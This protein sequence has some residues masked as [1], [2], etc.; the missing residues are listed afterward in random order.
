MFRTSSGR[1]VRSAGLAC[2]CPNWRWIIRGRLPYIRVPEVR[3]GEHRGGIPRPDD[4]GNARLAGWRTE[5]TDM[6]STVAVSKSTDLQPCPGEP[7]V[8]SLG[9]PIAK[10]GSKALDRALS[11][12]AALLVAAIVDRSS[13]WGRCLPRRG[14]LHRRQ[15]LAR[16]PTHRVSGLLTCRS[17]TSISRCDRGKVMYG[18]HRSKRSGARQAPTCRPSSID[19]A[20]PWFF[21]C[22]TTRV[23]SRNLAFSSAVGSRHVSRLPNQR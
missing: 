19:D 10:A 1:A 9:A 21:P 6:S 2:C 3:P 17:S 7:V 20:S 8:P 4:A 15:L 5:A 11:S 13:P 22:A 16:R 23:Q 12:I 14:E 18:V